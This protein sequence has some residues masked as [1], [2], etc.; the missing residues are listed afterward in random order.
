MNAKRV[1]FNYKKL[2]EAILY[3]LAH[4][5]DYTIEGKKKLAK[6]LY[7]VDFNC[8]EAFEKPITGATY[9]ALQMGPFPEEL[10]EILSKL[11]GKELKITKKTTG[12][13]NDTCV[14]S[15][16]LEPK[17]ISFE[18]LSKQEVQ[19]LDK[20]INDYSK[21]SGNDLGKITH[22]EAPYNAVAQGEYIPYELSFYR[23]KTME[24]LIGK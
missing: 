14:Y 11:E 18:N 24:E 23:G 7:F 17:D 1:D 15:L 10:N 5:P 8:F 13:P 4:S 12:L 3:L 2:R 20:V 21:L 16:N 19:I 6:L 22:S 9:R